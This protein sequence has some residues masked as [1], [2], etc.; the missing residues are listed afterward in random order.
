[1]GLS[2]RSILRSI[3]ATSV[4][5]LLSPWISGHIPRR[6]A[7]SEAA[8]PQATPWTL[9]WSDEFDQPDGSLPD[10]KKWKF[11]IGGNGWGNHG[12]E[13][14]TKRAANASVEQGSLGGRAR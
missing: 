11:E 1:M 2:P 4:G 3:V 14:Y 10:P 6:I 5:L 7:T 12:L 13:Y 8:Q 9:V